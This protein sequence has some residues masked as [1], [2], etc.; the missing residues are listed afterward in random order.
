MRMQII[1]VV[2]FALVTLEVSAQTQRPAVQPTAARPSPRIANP[3]AKVAELRRYVLERQTLEGWDGTTASKAIELQYAALR[4]IVASTQ[5][6]PVTIEAIRDVL[7]STDI[8]TQKDRS[9]SPA[10][11]I[12][13]TFRPG[14]RLQELYLRAL[15]LL[16]PHVR[17][18]IVRQVQAV[19]KYPR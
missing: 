19:Q 16:Q 13:L 10:L 2:S 4:E 14:N 7:L 12:D 8:L 1:F 18:R 15:E 5:A 9:D 17:D 6:D 3:F 11:Q